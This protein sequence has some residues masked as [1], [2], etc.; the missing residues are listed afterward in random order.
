MGV[1]DKGPYILVNLIAIAFCLW[2]LSP[3]L[4][5]IF[6][7]LF[8]LTKRFYNWLFTWQ[9]MRRLL[10]ALAILATLIA[11]FYTEENWRGKRD[12]EKCKA[13]LEAQ[14]AVL[15]W[16]KFIPLPV[17]DDQ[18]F[19]TFSTN[20]FK[21]KQLSGTNDPEYKSVLANNWLRLEGPILTNLPT[22]NTSKRGPILAQI[23]VLPQA[24]LDLLH[25]T[26]AL[27][28]TL[29][30]T[31][32][33]RRSRDLIQA[34][35]GPMIHGVQGFT[36][37]R[38]RPDENKPAQI[39]VQAA[40]PPSDNDLQKLIPPDTQLQIDTSVDRRT[41]NVVL[42]LHGPGIMAAADYIKW[43]DQFV[44]AF[45]DIHEALKRPY[46][47][48]PGDYSNPASM[49]IPNFVILR[50]LAQTLGQRAQCFLLLDQ[51]DK[52]LHELTLIHDVCR[53]L[54]KPPT[55]KSETLVEAMINVAIMGLYTGI[56]NDGFQ[57][58]QWKEPQ[59]VA[60]Q[61][62]LKEIDLPPFVFEALQEEPARMSYFAGTAKLPVWGT[63]KWLR[64]SVPRGWVYQMVAVAVK[65]NSQLAL[66]FD[67]ERNTISP[68]KIDTTM[69][70]IKD[71]V[72]NNSPFYLLARIAVP[73]VSKAWQNT[74]YNQTMAN[75]AQIASAL[76]RY[77]LAHGEYPETLDALS[78]QFMETFP[79]DIIG[80]EPPIYRRTDDGK[81]LLYSIGWNETDDGGQSVSRNEFGV[82][83][84]FTQGDWVWPN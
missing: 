32:D 62:Q 51:P 79:Q 53:I 29:N 43:S 8:R 47:I 33:A 31:N 72:A 10:I 14:G 67:P 49:P 60:L 77:Y 39:F 84:N 20:F 1:A 16:D 28:V 27:F 69:Q 42:R 6:P 65:Q 41:F 54:E 59:L 78:P 82:V 71:A 74:A 17:P 25:G 11:A 46:A 19:F 48:I 34:T 56:I 18:N 50:A 70:N 80:G 35:M 64:W 83:T 37:S 38:F 44:P 22:W 15:D 2:L 81:F 3:I 58:R 52:A 36:F 45:D 73:N 21:F 13:Q 24:N 4:R 66:G 7:P 55:G 12:W 30:D 75:Q 5:L 63:P 9:T 57:H 23:T 40:I 76:E 26:N 61:E 68:Q